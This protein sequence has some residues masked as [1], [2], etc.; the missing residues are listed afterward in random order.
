M[1]V[2]SGVT[3]DTT[4]SGEGAVATSGVTRPIDA[5]HTAHGDGALCASGCVWMS[6]SQAIARAISKMNVKPARRI[7]ISVYQGDGPTSYSV[8]RYGLVSGAE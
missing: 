8:A 1:C 5:T 7:G 4:T 2:T 6:G 3:A